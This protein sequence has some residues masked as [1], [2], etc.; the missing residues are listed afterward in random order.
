MATMVQPQR[1][2]PQPPHP[3][4]AIG[5]GVIAILM[6]GLIGLVVAGAWLTSV[7]ER[8]RA[9]GSTPSAAVESAAGSAVETQQAEHLSATTAVGGRPERLR[10][11]RIDVD[12]RLMDLGLTAKRELEV[13]PLSRAGTAGWYD[14]SPVPG[15]VGPSILAGHVD[16]STGPAVFF[17]LH[18]LRMGDTVVVDRSDGRTATFVVDRVEQVAKSA[19]PTRRVYG[20]TPRPE[21]RLITCGGTFDAATGHYLAN[22]V[23]YAHLTTLTAS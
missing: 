2:E 3:S 23:V 11:P 10:V 5:L 6:A 13:P 19:F 17:R 8:P 1:T 7:E 15:E 12:T 22:V 9:A 18:E 20:A 21:L 14:R 4:G 16:S